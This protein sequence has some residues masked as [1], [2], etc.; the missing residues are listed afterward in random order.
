MTKWM[1][2]TEFAKEGLKISK[3]LVDGV[4]HM[5]MDKI[6]QGAGDLTAFSLEK[7]DMSKKDWFM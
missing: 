4:L 5:N 7:Y 3:S 6:G 1:A 2:P